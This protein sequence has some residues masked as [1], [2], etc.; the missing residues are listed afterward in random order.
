MKILAIVCRVLLGLIFVVFGL[1]A[2]LQFIPAGPLPA[3]VTTFMTVMSQGG[4]LKAIGAFQ[5][6]GGL[7]VLYG[8]TVPLGLI[9]LCP[10]TVNI[11]LFHLCMTGGA[12][13]FPG[14]L[15]TVFELILIYRYRANFAGIL[16]AD[17][18]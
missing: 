14:L 3:N 11:L 2:F 15:V 12:G 16:T 1:N 8:G 17:A 4:W 10:I 6:L 7:L 13:I 9:I 18:Q 5:V